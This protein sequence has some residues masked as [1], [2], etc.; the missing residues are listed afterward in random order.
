MRYKIG[1]VMNYK[2]GCGDIITPEK[3]YLFLDT[4]VVEGKLENNDLVI[5]GDEDKDSRAFFVKKIEKKPITMTKYT[6]KDQ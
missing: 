1:K 5:F 6:K 4:D 2:A 3:K